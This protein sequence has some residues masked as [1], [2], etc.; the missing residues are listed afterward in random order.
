M[1]LRRGKPELPPPLILKIWIPGLGSGH[2]PAVWRAAGASSISG[3]LP[4]F[5]MKVRHGLQ[6]ICA[7]TDADEDYG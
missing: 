5:V 7:E 4:L 1:K 6:S 3:T 2:H